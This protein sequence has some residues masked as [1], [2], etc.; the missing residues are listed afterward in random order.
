MSVYVPPG[1]RAQPAPS[2]ANHIAAH[3]AKIPRRQDQ[4][5]VERFRA[6]TG[7]REEF[8]T[9]Y[10]EE[11]LR[12]GSC[13]VRIRRSGKL[14]PC[15]APLSSIVQAL[16]HHDIHLMYMGDWRV[17]RATVNAIRDV[18]YPVE[19]QGMRAALTVEERATLTSDS[20]IMEKAKARL[21]APRQEEE[22]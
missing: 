11:F 7:N 13:P 1:E 3:E 9:A 10:L 4:V 16:A 19:I 22:G 20:R 21:L 12:M 14:E 17:Q 8:V 6:E 18:A 5:V 15:G 2:P